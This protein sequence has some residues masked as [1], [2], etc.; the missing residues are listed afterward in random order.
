MSGGTI[1]TSTRS[2]PI[3]DSGIVPGGAAIDTGLID[4]SNSNLGSYYLRHENMSAVTT[5]VVSVN[6]VMRD[7]T[8][9]TIVSSSAAPGAAAAANVNGPMLRYARF[10]MVA[11][12]SDSA[13][14]RI[15]LTPE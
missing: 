1:T 13:R 2:F 10:I 5:R 9:V 11:A 4:L 3:W 12:G 6:Y 15:A 14:M 8:E 7:G